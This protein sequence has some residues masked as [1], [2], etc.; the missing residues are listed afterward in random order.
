MTA[1]MLPAY[2]VVMNSK[3]FDVGMKFY[4]WIFFAMMI[5]RGDFFMW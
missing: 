1:I 2:L 5:I 4:R 3:D